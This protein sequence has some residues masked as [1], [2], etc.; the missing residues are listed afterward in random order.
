MSD[1]DFIPGEIY[2]VQKTDRSLSHIM[3]KM[4]KTSVD[5]WVKANPGLE[6]SKIRVGQDLVIPEFPFSFPVPSED[7]T[8][9][10]SGPIRTRE[11]LIK[12]IEK[13]S[14][15]IDPQLMIGLIEYE[16]HGKHSV[17][18]DKAV[19]LGQ[20]TPTAIKELYRLGYGQVDASKP[21]QNIRAASKLLENYI[22]KAHEFEVAG[23][24]G[25]MNIVDVALMMYH[26]GPDGVKQW[27]VAGMPKEVPHPK[28]PHVGPKTI[29]YPGQVYKHA[30][31]SKRFPW[32]EQ[33]LP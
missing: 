21:V 26:S 13:H 9:V 22:A 18:N 31:S 6:P 4:P 27:L 3:R 24:T 19:G 8:D 2:T 28:A 15:N 32:F 33:Y 30:L 11:D 7:I 23:L 17:V 1:K 12:L 5:D 29:A 16:S 25:D 14:G 20:L 10:S